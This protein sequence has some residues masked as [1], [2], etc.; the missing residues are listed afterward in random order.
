MPDLIG[1]P[2][3]D[4]EEGLESMNL[5]VVIEEAWS[6]E[7]EGL[8]TEQQPSPGSTIRAGDTVTLTVSGGSDV[9][10]DVNL[11]ERI[12]LKGAV[13]RQK[14]IRPGEMLGITL[15]WEAIR[16]INERYVVFVHVFGPD[17]DLV[18]QEDREPHLP[19]TQWDQGIE[20]VDPHQLTVPPGSPSG[21]YQ[22]RVGMYPAGEPGNRLSVA[23]AGRT[24]QEANSILVAEVDVRQ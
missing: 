20:I 10:L 1:R 12:I 8:V 16:S 14:T 21:R 15:R 6:T 4:M 22:L 13:L 2:A 18:A 9:I 19:T 23:D 5:E 3:E 7:P 24:S 17:G 11:A